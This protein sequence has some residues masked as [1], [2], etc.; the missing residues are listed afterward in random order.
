MSTKAEQHVPLRDGRRIRL[1]DAVPKDAEAA[2]I[3]VRSVC[4]EVRRYVRTEPDEFQQD[5]EGQRRWIENLEPSRGDHMLIA[6]PAGSREIIG[7]LRVNAGRKRKIAHVGELAMTVRHAWQGLGVGSA[8]LA[9]AIER[10]EACPALTKLNLEVYSHN[11]RAIRLYERFGFQRAGVQPKE[12]QIEPG[13]FVDT[14]LIYRWVE[15]ATPRSTD[16]PG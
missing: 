10:P 13:E 15:E 14:V 9:A 1:R 4:P 8:P 3:Y 2:L 5:A 6:L 12:A 7:T 11:D 16:P